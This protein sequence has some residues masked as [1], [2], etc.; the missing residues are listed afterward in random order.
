MQPIKDIFRL[1]CKLYLININS[2]SQKNLNQKM[3][4]VLLTALAALSI[5]SAAMAQKIDGK[6]EFK[7][8]AEGVRVN[9][10]KAQKPLNKGGE[11]VSTWYDVID[12]MEQ[13]TAGGGLRRYVDFL[14]HDS[15]NKFVDD[16]G[17]VR[18]GSTISVGHIFDPKDD[19]IQ[20]T[21]NP[22]NQLSRFN[23]YKLDSVA[24]SYLYVR[25]VD[26][27]NDGMGGTVPVVDTL[28][29]AYWRGPQIANRAFQ[30][31]T[32]YSLPNATA[33]HWNFATRMPSGYFAIDTFLL[34]SGANGIFDTTRVSNNDGGFE[35]GWFSKVSSIKAPEGVS[36]TA[37]AAGT[38]QNLLT[39]FSFTF[40]SGVPA[41]VG[42][43]TAV[44]CY[45]QDP[46]TAPAGMR[47]SNYFGYGLYLNEGAI[48]WENTKFNNTPL[49]GAKSSSYATVNGWNGYIAGQA[50]TNER[51]VQTFFHISVDTTNGK[52]GVGL[53]DVAAVKINSVFPNPANSKVNVNMNLVSAS[54]VT[55]TLTNL[56]GQEVSTLSFPNT[57]AGTFELPMNTSNFNAGV[58]MINITAGNYTASQKLVITK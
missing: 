36:V 5:G 51:F 25:N 21:D 53:N 38:N 35:N 31:G 29:V 15:L 19:L 22:E 41:V 55:V 7:Y 6:G 18:Y 34:S 30:D 54:D 13:S 8:H 10:F 58:Y 20:N 48:G 24:F 3:K 32:R 49:I 27:V 33:P 11:P 28:F 52:P 4:K 2:K 39:A 14:T 50:F 56:M 57:P 46:A 40:K 23:S 9:P 1:S 26:Q 37:N 44:F 45:Q 42:T 16:D 17:T 47:R 43:D 12:M